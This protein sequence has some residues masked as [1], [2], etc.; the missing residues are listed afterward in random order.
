LSSIAALQADNMY[1]PYALLV[2]YATWNRLLDDFKAE[3]DKTILQR[4]REL[5]D[6]VSIVASKEVEAETAYFVQ[7]TSDVIDEV[8]GLEPTTVQWETQGGMQVHFKVMG[9]MIPRIRS[10]VTTQSG[11]AKIS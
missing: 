1:G 2:T 10:T 5:P 9:I 3:S 8:I 4:L 11:V 6:I 7:L